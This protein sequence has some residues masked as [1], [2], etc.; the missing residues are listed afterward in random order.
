MYP[1]VAVGEYDKAEARLAA[2]EAEAEARDANKAVRTVITITTDIGQRL[3]L[4]SCW[5]GQLQST[6]ATQVADQTTCAG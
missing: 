1:I 2:A 4:S 6:E 5:Q 3:T